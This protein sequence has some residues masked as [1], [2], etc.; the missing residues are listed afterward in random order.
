MLYVAGWT[1][2]SLKLA[3]VRQQPVQTE[4]GGVAASCGLRDEPGAA[5]RDSLPDVQQITL[6]SPRL[7]I[8]ARQQVE[9]DVCLQAVL[10][11]ALHWQ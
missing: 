1:A 2:G 8:Y 7:A 11:S 5:A 4:A 3:V 9:R 10:D 6:H